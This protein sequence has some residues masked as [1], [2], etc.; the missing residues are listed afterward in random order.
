MLNLTIPVEHY[1]LQEG[2]AVPPEKIEQDAEL[3]SEK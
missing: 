1:S 2:I 3:I